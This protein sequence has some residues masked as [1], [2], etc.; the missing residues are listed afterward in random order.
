M[1]I[2]EEMYLRHVENDENV[3]QNETSRIH[4][5]GVDR[6]GQNQDHRQDHRRQAESV[7]YHRSSYKFHLLILSTSWLKC[8]NQQFS[9]GFI[10]TITHKQHN[11]HGLT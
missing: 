4:E 7:R 8:P 6:P 9:V 5:H 2:R 11:T 1:E 10:G 3:V